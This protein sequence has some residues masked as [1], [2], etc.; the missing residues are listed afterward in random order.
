MEANLLPFLKKSKESSGSNLIIKTREPDISESSEEISDS[1]AIE[2]AAQDLISA[3]KADDVKAVAAALQA[4]FE[5]CDSLPHEEGEH[6]NEPSP[7]SYDSQNRK[8]GE[9]E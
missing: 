8:A 3:I 2:S 1:S 9:Q 4:A 6:T 5:M 7:H